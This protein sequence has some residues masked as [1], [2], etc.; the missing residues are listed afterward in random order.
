MTCPRPDLQAIPPGLIPCDKGGI[1]AVDPWPQP[2]RPRPPRPNVPGPALVIQGGGAKGSVAVGMAL[3]LIQDRGVD[4]RILRGNS[5][6]ALIGAIL[7]Q[8]PT[9]AL[10]LAQLRRQATVLEHI[11]RTEIRGNRSVYRTR[12]PRWRGGK[13]A[14][15]VKFALGR[16]DSVYDTAPL[17]ALIQRYVSTYHIRHSGRDLAVGMVGLRSGRYFEQSGRDGIW[18]RDLLAS[19]AIPLLASAAIPGVF[20]PRPL[21]CEDMLVDGCVRNYTSIGSAIKAGATEVYVLVCGPMRRDAETGA[22]ESCIERGSY[23]DWRR[24]RG[25]TLIARALEIH[26]DEVATDDLNGALAWNR[27]L[28]GGTVTVRGYGSGGTILD[29]RRVPIHVIAPEQPYGAGALDF[30]PAL[31]AAAIDHG[32]EVGADP[33]RW[34]IHDTTTDTAFSSAV[35][36]TEDAEDSNGRGE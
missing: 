9:G 20:P 6:G 25:V 14:S 1:E 26:S 28:D 33:G 29:K 16:T 30:D 5:V 31:I 32:R 2:P 23:D 21:T 11:W 8:A 12:T 35:R 36:R 15:V 24:A 7:A 22:L 4:A 18:P 10:S 34:L 19:A 3:G 27:R 17:R 13:W